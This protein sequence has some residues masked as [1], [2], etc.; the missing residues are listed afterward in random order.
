MCDVCVCVMC[1]C[2]RCVLCVCYTFII[3]YLREWVEEREDTECDLLGKGVTCVL[4]STAH[5]LAIANLQ[6]SL[7]KIGM[8]SVRCLL[9]FSIPPRGG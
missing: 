6:C 5:Y 8:H 3:C 9:Q 1:L 2:V 7:F 4:S